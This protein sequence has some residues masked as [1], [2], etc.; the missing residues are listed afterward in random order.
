[1][2][3]GQR[4]TNPRKGTETIHPPTGKKIRVPRQ[5]NTNPRKGTETL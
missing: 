4:N 3:R 1:M 5:R 2:D